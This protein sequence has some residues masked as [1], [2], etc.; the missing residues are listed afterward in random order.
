MSR[1]TLW[2]SLTALQCSLKSLKSKPDSLTHSLTHWV[3]R[4][5]IE[6]SWTAKNNFDPFPKKDLIKR[7]FAFFQVWKGWRHWP[8]QISLLPNYTRQS[9]AIRL[10]NVCVGGCHRLGCLFSVIF[11]EYFGLIW[12]KNWFLS[13]AADVESYV[14]WFLACN[15]QRFPYW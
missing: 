3:T 4:S 11:R 10:Q 6:L 7:E 14:P 5:P 15:P 12:R 9:R 8:G 1:V 2:C 13:K